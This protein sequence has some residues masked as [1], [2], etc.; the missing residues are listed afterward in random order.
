MKV[1][2]EINCNSAAFDDDP[3]PE[4]TRLLAMVP[5]KVVKQMH[6]PSCMCDALESVDKLLDT[7]GNTVGR[8]IVDKRDHPPCSDEVFVV[9]TRRRDETMP[10][11]AK[12]CGH[13][14]FFS[15]YDADDYEDGLRIADGPYGIFRCLLTI[16]EEVKL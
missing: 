5:R 14:I 6:R 11:A 10:K 16:E 13:R 2:I 7:N 1:T 4:L 9:A 15:E 12:I 3:I 8:V